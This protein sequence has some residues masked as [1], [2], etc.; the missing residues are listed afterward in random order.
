MYICLMEIMLLYGYS[1]CSEL[2]DFV[3]TLNYGQLRTLSNEAQW[4]PLWSLGLSSILG[5]LTPSGIMCRDGLTY[6]SVVR[7]FFHIWP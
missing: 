6:V 1:E 7:A 5:V 3:C 2:Q 4:L